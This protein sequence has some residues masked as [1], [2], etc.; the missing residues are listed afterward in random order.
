[1]KRWGYELTKTRL[2]GIFRLK[3]GGFYG[4]TRIQDPKSDRRPEVTGVFRDAKTPKEAQ[5]LLDERANDARAKLQGAPA[6]TQTWRS[7]A[8]SR[9]NERIRKGKV[10]SEATVERWREAIGIFEP[11]WGELNAADVTHHHI[12][13]WLATTVAGWMTDGRTVIRK[14]RVGGELQGV[15]FT[16][17]LKATT[18]NGWLRVLRAISHAIKTKFGLAKSAFD[19]VEFFEEGRIYT[20]EEPNALPTEL[21]PQFMSIAR[22]KFPQH[23]AMIFLG[24]ATGLRPSSMRPLRRSGPTPDVDWE[25]GLLFIRRSHSRK[26]IVMNKTKTGRDQTIALPKEV[27]DEL[28]VHVEALK[29]K[30]EA[31]ELLFPSDVGQLRT[32]NVLAKPFAAIAEEMQLGFRLT[33]RGMRRTFVDAQRKAGIEA[34]VS[35]SIS[36]H[37]TPTMREHYSTASDEEQREAIRRT[38]RLLRG[39]GED[40]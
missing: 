37:T 4:R 23:F 3:S 40:S 31:S 36:G 25:K 10:M 14:R 33:P 34:I 11:E 22:K 18:V 29:G 7:F 35:N 21:L 9:L 16:T 27:L 15:P 24:M 6:A 28:R 32:R 39:E 20:R 17:K 30:M 5:T 38:N 12:D 19:G 2:P 1:M 26:Q 8:V 13:H